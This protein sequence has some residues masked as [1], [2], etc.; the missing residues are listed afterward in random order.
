MNRKWYLR[1]NVAAANNW[2]TLSNTCGPL[3]TNIYKAFVLA[4]PCLSAC[5]FITFRVLER[6]SLRWNWLDSVS[7]ISHNWRGS[8]AVSDLKLIVKSLFKSCWKPLLFIFMCDVGEARDVIQFYRQP[9]I[10]RAVLLVVR[11]VDNISLSYLEHSIFF[12]W[13]TGQNI[14]FRAS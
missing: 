1:F 10:W 8:G 13:I 5:P 2:E 3:S 14:V 12:I 7:Y 11:F 4:V 9:L 6:V